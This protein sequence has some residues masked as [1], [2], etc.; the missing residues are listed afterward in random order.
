MR[1]FEGGSGYRAEVAGKES[2]GGG[3]VTRLGTGP[4]EQLRDLEEELAALRGFREE[5][6]DS[7]KGA[8]QECPPGLV[9]LC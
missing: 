7:Q 8:D 9:G 4:W 2:R 1:F 6:G 5:G 3:H